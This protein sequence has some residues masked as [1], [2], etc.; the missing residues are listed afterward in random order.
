MPE[1]DNVVRNV[2]EV[3][4][5]KMYDGV[6]NEVDINH[7]RMSAAGGEETLSRT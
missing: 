7:I 2:I 1:E 4:K 5:L 6:G 3:N